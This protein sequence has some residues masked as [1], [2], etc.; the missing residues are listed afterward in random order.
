MIDRR[1]PLRLHRSRPLRRDARARSTTTAACR[2]SP[3]WRWPTPAPAPIVVAPS[4]MMDGRVARHPRRTRRG[5]ASTTRDHV[6]RGEVR[7][8]LLRPVPRGR[9]LGARRGGPPALPDGLPQ[10]ARGAA[11]SRSSTSDEGADIVMVK[12]ALAYLDVIARRRR[13]RPPC[14]VAAY[15]VSG[16]YSPR[17]AAAA[18]G[19]STSATSCWRTSPPYARGRAISSSPIT[20]RL[21]LARGGCDR[22]TATSRALRP[23]QQ[24]HAGGRQFAGAG[25]S[26]GRRNAALHR[27]GERLP[28][29]PTP[30]AQLPRLRQLVGTADPRPRAPGGRAGGPRRPPP[31]ISYGA[32]CAEEVE[33]AEKVVDTVPGVEQVRFVSSG[34]E[35]VMSAVRLARGVTGRDSDRQVRR[36]LPRPRRRSAGRGRLG[37]R[38]LRHALF[39]RR[40]GEFAGPHAACCRS[41]TR[42]RSKSC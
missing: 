27:R 26:L 39:G 1:L 28:R 24:G 14:R 20:R 8:G 32:P 42:P 41:T 9:R 7:V 35:A 18:K 37:T 11:R 13:G 17:Q 5:T 21:A 4:D 25:V 34:T 33:L 19:W 23:R 3:T 38:D 30:T 40:A 16:E 15:N 6:L 2:I 36:L 31:G 29:S 22:R 10:P 12:P